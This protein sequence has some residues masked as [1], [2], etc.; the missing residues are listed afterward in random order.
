M[1]LGDFFR[2]APLSHPVNPRPVTFT[3]VCNSEVLPGGKEN[4]NRA[5][6]SAKV[7]GAFCFLDGQMA[8]ESRI[9]AR[10]ALQERFKDSSGMPLDVD[11][12]DLNVETLY[13]QIWRVLLEWDPDS[14]TTGDRLFPGVENVRELVLPSEA[15]KIWNAYSK[16]VQDEHPEGLDDEPFRQPKSASP[17]VARKEPVRQASAA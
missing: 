10:R 17:R 15:Q 12:I 13:Q 7:T 6:V 14:K 9:E 16:Y 1:K 8:Q 11:P 5:A 3:C 2:S 4:P